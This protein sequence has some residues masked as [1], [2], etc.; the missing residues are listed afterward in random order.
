MT[1]TPSVSDPK[2]PYETRLA[3]ATSSYARV[4]TRWNLVANLRLVAFLVAVAAAAWGLWGRAPLGW[5]LAGLL[6]VLFFVLASYHAQ[7]GRERARLATLRAIEEDA[8]ARIDRRWAD[9]PPPWLPSVPPE[10]PYAIDLDIV[11]RASLFHFL[12]TTATRMG[13]ETLASWLLAPAPVATVLARQGAVAE[14]APRLD[15]RQEL[16]L[17]GRAAANDEADPA[18]FLA[19]AEA[20]DGLDSRA[21]LRL[22]AWLGPLALVL[23]VIADRTGLIGYPL[24]IVPLLANLLIGG[25]IARQAYATIADVAADHRAIAAYAG[26]LDLLA[27]ASFSDPLLRNVQERLGTGERGAPAMLRRLGRLASMAIPPSSILYI[28]IQ[29]LTMWDV[30]V[31]AALERWKREGGHAARLWLE[32]LGEAEALAAL[33]GP[34]H[35]NPAWVFPAVD[36]ATDAYRATRIGHPLL[37]EDAR[38]RNDVSIGPPGTFLLVTGSNMSGKS[39]LLRA[40]GVNA[41]LAQAGGAVCADALSLPPV[42]L[43]TS[44]RVQDS[45]ERGVSFFL[46]ELQRLKLIVDAATRAHEGNDSR[47]MYL[48]D[49][50]LQGTNTAERGVAARRII[51][52][53]VEQGAIGAVSTHDLALADDPRLAATA[54]SVHFTDTVGEGPDAPPMSF[55]YRLRPGVATTTNALRLMRLIGLDLEDA[56]V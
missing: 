4:N 24:W 36:P 10:H 53:L 20:P 19:W 56:P 48:L 55:D 31:L 11:G 38:V 18:A 3:T 43:W 39:T 17:R 47:V 7:L 5:P 35:D 13:R 54:E 34:R 15:A 46:A 14:L 40:V 6:L 21:W 8:I 9:L 1:Q 23:L 12:D 28:P 30:H 44:V 22:Y 50:I 26:Q 37:R 29:A 52:Y 32:T 16:Q 45:L 27:G 51:A 49:E 42:E 41:V 33:A 25:T 2:E